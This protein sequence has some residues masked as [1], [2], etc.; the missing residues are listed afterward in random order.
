MCRGPPFFSRPRT[1]STWTL[2]PA[3]FRRCSKRRSSH[4]DQ[5]AST[6]AGFSAA[7]TAASPPSSYSR[8]L[9]G[10]GEGG[11]A[12]VDVEQH[13][14]E[15]ARALAQ[16]GGDVADRYL[17]PPILQRM[18]RQRSQR[19]AIPLDHRRHQLR[20]DDGGVGRQHVEG[21]AQ[22]EPHAEAADQDA[23]LVAGSRPGAAKRRERFLRAVHA[24]RH[25]RLA[26]CQDHVLGPLTGEA[27]VLAVG[28]AGLTE[29]LPRS[30]DPASASA[31]QG[32]ARRRPWSCAS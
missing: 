5:T 22:R 17:D 25:Q 19:P 21:R 1:R 29:Q 10:R 8:V 31:A 23:R 32:Q 15:A 26:A 16:R 27:H 18:L 30:H 12:V 24:A 7:R 9:C 11:R 3:C 14:V 20:D 28:G 4:A 6:P 2:K 13:R